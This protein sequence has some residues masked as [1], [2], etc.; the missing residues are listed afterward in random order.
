LT[1]IEPATS[2]TTNRRSNQLSYNRRAIAGD[3]AACWRGQHARGLRR[4]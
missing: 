1:G 3:T 2:G 4:L